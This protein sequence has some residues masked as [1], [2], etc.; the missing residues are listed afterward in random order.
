MLLADKHDLQQRL[1]LQILQIEEKELQHYTTNAN[2]LGT[3]AAL[4]A[5]FAFTTLIEAPW[6]DM[7]D[8]SPK[9]LVL[10]AVCC[11]VVAM[12]FQVMA[13]L[14]S[15]QLSILGPKLALRGPDGSMKRAVL[16][17]RRQE[18][19][20]HWYFYAGLC[21]FHPAATFTV[22]AMFPWEIACAA[23]IALAI[24]LVWM[25]IDSIWLSDAL[26]LPAGR[27]AG[28]QNLWTDSSDPDRLESGA[29]AAPPRTLTATRVAVKRD[30]TKGRGARAASTVDATA[31]RL[32][33]QI[34]AK[35]TP[36]ASPI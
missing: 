12:I 4:L 24:G 1:K 15:V 2:S 33:D 8:D 22:W 26:L 19:I 3:Q 25:L 18:I 14:K 9:W 29:A 10:M 27:A 11:D 30:R 35:A 7:L 17:M 34:G 20:M 28:V 5:G 13:T 23:S 32:I 36:R 16:A 21:V 6:S 31:R